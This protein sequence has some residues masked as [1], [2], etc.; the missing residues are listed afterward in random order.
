MN[1]TSASAMVRASRGPIVLMTLGALFA[2]DYAGG[3]PF[4]RTWP[5][6]LIV[7]GVLWL[8][9]RVVGRDRGAGMAGGSI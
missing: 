1:S 7:Y 8:L 2:L 4:Y 9:E 3:Y 5:L 6:L